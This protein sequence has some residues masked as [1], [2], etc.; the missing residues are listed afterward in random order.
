MEKIIERI[1]NYHIVNTLIPGF[2]FVYLS[3]QLLSVDLYSENVLYNFFVFYMLGII[4]NRIGS[5]IIEPFFKLI[6]IVKFAPYEE[7]V[8]AEQKNPKIE[9]LNTD[10]NFYRTMCA[11]ILLVVAERFYIYLIA[12]SPFVAS[13]K[14]EILIILTL[15]LFSFSYHKQTSYI[16]KRVD[17]VNKQNS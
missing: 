6:R 5:I 11:T 1:S 12:V 4:C 10:N 7:Y 17:A 16:K 14:S 15:V 9:T 8:K 13:Y 2:I 3:K